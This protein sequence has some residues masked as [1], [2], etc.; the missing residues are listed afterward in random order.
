MALKGTRT[1][2][3]YIKEDVA[4]EAVI[5]EEYHTMIARVTKKAMESKREEIRKEVEEAVEKFVKGLSYN[6]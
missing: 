3:K 2:P 4:I 6:V 5:R 1:T